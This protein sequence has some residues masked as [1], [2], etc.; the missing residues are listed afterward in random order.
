MMKECVF[1]FFLFFLFLSEEYLV[2]KSHFL[3]VVDSK[4]LRFDN[5]TKM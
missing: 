5:A 2:E 1:F 3:T 4:L